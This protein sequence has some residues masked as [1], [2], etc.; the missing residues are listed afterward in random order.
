M[1]QHR[2]CS[3]CRLSLH[4]RVLHVSSAI[5][6]YRGVQFSTF[7]VFLL[8]SEF[9]G[10]ITLQHL[11]AIWSASAKTIKDHTFLKFLSVLASIMFPVIK[12]EN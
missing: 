8:L 4:L 10:D 1:G 7:T 3:V 9:S 2:Q 12:K 6:N 11:Q 5:K